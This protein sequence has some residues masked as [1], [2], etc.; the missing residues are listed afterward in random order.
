MK[1]L[2]SCA[3]KK[4]LWAMALPAVVSK[5]ILNEAVDFLLWPFMCFFFPIIFFIVFPIAMVILAAP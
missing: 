1:K 4:T 5:M 2:I 3:R